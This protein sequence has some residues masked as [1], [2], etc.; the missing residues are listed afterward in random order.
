MT[1]VIPMAGRG[2][3]FT[4][5]GYEQPKMLIEA[6]GKTLLQWSVDSLPLSLC[7]R[8]VFI[9]LRAHE[10][11]H[12]LT[13][14]IRDLYGKTCEIHFHWLDDVTRG[15]AETVLMAEHL[16]PS[17]RPLLIYNIDTAFYSP[18][19]PAVLLDSRNEGVLGAFRSRDPRFS[20][21]LPGPGGE[22]ER[23]VEKEPISDCAL[24][25]LYYCREAADFLGA[26]KE[27][28]ARGATVRG[29][30][31]VAPILNEL[32]AK[33]RRFVVDWAEAHHILGTPEELQ[34]FLATGAGDLCP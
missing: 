17:D 13:E 26:A 32:V 21:A 18:T 1:I 16:I 12:G 9:G 20:F 31:Y 34:T 6:H 5:A 8:M 27:A 7:S 10:S 11:G 22:V 28:V 2:E 19:L 14:M 3:R 4:N 30:F 24:T 29:E 23:I 15:Q 25:G 33:G